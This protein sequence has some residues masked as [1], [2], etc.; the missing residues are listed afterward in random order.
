MNM[1][2]ADRWIRVA[3]AALAAVLFFT[4]TVSG[5]L[6]IVLMAVAVI[7]ALTSIVKFCP[8]YAI[9]GARTCPAEQ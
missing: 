8:I 7:F 6:G 2:N 3:I 1:G 5:V 9:F 4:D